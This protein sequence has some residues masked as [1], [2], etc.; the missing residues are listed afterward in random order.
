MS[1]TDLF[2]WHWGL[3]FLK[4]IFPSLQL[5]FLNYCAFSRFCSFF[6][7]FTQALTYS[8]NK[9]YL[10]SMKFFIL[11]NKD[12]ITISYVELL[13]VQIASCD[14]YLSCVLNR[15]CILLRF[16]VQCNGVN[17]STMA[18]KI[19]WLFNNARKKSELHYIS[20]EYFKFHGMQE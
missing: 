11:S 20:S 15:V 14:K 9:N 2:N 4:N 13:Y 6:R 16:V 18:V 10:S 12:I 5:F 19:A 7:Y 17:T 1:R 3:D 8:K